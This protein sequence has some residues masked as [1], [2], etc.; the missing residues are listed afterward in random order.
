MFQQK[1]NFN[2]FAVLYQCG[3]FAFIFTSLFLAASHAR[4]ETEA[5]FTSLNHSVSESQ[6]FPSAVAR[7]IQFSGYTW[8]IKSGANLGPGKNNWSNSTDDVWIDDQGRLHLRIVKYEKKWYCTEIISQNYFGYGRFYFFLDSRVD[9]LDPNVVLG[10]FTYHDVN[11]NGII[12]PELGDGEIDIEFSRWGDPQ[13][14]F[15]T[16]YAV[17]PIPS[18]KSTREQFLTQLNGSRSTHSFNWQAREVQFLSMHGLY[19][20]PPDDSFIIYQKTIAHANVPGDAPERVHINF[21]ID[22]R[23]PA[24][25]PLEVIINRFAYEHTSPITPTATPLPDVAVPDWMI[26]CQ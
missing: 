3:R 20:T 11:S 10:L 19:K 24:S 12:E 6:T 16:T 18:D 5:V 1:T 23:Y 8:N 17:Q 2:L 13:A 14:D 25:S 22:T 26:Y 21:W 9:Q 7:T 15:N 4:S